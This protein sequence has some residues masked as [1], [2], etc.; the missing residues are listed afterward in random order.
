[1]IEMRREKRWPADISMEILSLYKQ[2]NEK[3]ENIHQPID[4]TDI[5]NAGIGFKSKAELP[6]DYYF[7]ASIT[8]AQG[9]VLKCVVHIIRRTR[10]KEDEYQYGC[11]IVGN[12][13]IL[14]YIINDYA[15]S[16]RKR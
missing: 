14:E 7:N 3:V 15:A 11:E 1:M 4:I 6:L 5:S 8:L 16:L 13:F 9:E 10:P 2:G 12:S